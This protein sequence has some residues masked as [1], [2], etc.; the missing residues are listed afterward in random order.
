MRHTRLR[1]SVEG[2]IPCFIVFPR[3]EHSN[4][5]HGIV[6]SVKESLSQKGF[7][8]YLLS[9][10]DSSDGDFSEKFERIV[11]E[12]ILG[13]VILDG[14]RPNLLYEYG[15]IRGKGKLI[16]PVQDK[17]D[18][19]TIQ[20]SYSTL[21]GIKEDFN[22]DSPDF[23][24]GF[25]S[26]LKE[27][28][29]SYFYHLSKSHGINTTLVDS[30][31]ER[32]SSEHPRNKVQKEIEALISRMV[33]NYCEQSLKLVSGI[34]SDDLLRFR[35]TIL[36]ILEHHARERELGIEEIDNA[37]NEILRLE[38]S[39]GVNISPQI[40]RVYSLLAHLYTSLAQKN[41]WD[42][43]DEWKASFNKAIEIYERILE[44]E[45]E[46]ILQSSVHKKVGDIYLKTSE[47]EDKRENCKRAIGS[48][49]EALKFYNLE[50]FPAD[51]AS[52]QNN[53]GVSYDTLAEV[54][55]KAENC[56]KAIE[57][58]GVALKVRT[59]ES[60]PLDYAATQNNLG[61]AYS[62]LAEIEDKEE[63]CKLAI[64][65]YEEALRVYVFE[66]YPILY[67]Y[68]NNNLGNANR[69]LAE[70]QDKSENCKKAIKSYERTLKFYNLET[71][72]AD[73]ASTQNNLGVSYDTLAEVENKAENCKKAIE[74]YGV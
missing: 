61:I 36:D 33:E 6:S 39:Y 34:G 40:S 57:S 13:V 49:E 30:D 55:N 53:L 54:E 22:G 47:Y 44:F 19:S 73:Y 2:E 41:E 15:F 59:F 74:S 71:F 8:A 58:Y 48:Y 51:Y 63:S 12:C 35:K 9:D 38:E 7:K 21:D 4:Y 52:T 50:T 70:I 3:K 24:K 11:E 1:L 66:D 25:I 56:K 69:T 68:A 10:D 72:P 5:I 14:P 28:S 37:Y 45:T 23:E 20:R 18:F 16:V 29:I 32:S 64:K 17:R 60:A 42:K 43:S 27:S 31:A 62:V 65:A 26:N 46:S 67:A